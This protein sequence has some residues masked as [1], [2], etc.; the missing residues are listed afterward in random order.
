MIHQSS[1]LLRKKIKS[2]LISLLTKIHFKHIN[3]Q[4]KFQASRKILYIKN[5]KKNHSKN[6]YNQKWNTPQDKKNKIRRKVAQFCKTVQEFP[7]QHRIRG[8]IVDLWL[9]LILSN[10]RLQWMER[11]KEMILYP[12]SNRPHKHGKK[13][14]S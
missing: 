7:V 4:V 6:L 2:T 12:F 1:T 11:R 13:I 9:L 14:N 3:L 5:M 10:S 8:L